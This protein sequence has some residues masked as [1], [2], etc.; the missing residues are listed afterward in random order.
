MRGSTANNYTAICDEFTR[1]LEDN[2]KRR[3]VALDDFV[4][5]TE[6][7]RRHVQRALSYEGVSWR[8]ALITRRLREGARLL[9]ANPA[10]TVGEI[11][12]KVGYSQ[13]AQF[14]RTFREHMDMSPLEYRETRRR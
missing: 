7:S 4:S 12:E 3:D 13:P 5:T 1:W 14:S 10:L 8:L 9:R 11:A 2:Y 6:H